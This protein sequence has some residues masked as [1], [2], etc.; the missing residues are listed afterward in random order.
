M[1]KKVLFLFLIIYGC[2]DLNSYRIKEINRLSGITF[3]NSIKIIEYNDDLET[4]LI[5]KIR[6]DN[7]EIT[8][9]ENK[10]SNNKMRCFFCIFGENLYL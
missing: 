8:D 4:N 6:L 7:N 10:G 9:V 2:S 5:F 1:I 3:S